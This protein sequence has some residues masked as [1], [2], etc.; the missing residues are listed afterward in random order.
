MR[1]HAV[2]Y[3]SMRPFHARL[4]TIILRTGRGTA[5]VYTATTKAGVDDGQFI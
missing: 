5:I 1:K 3:I 4:G 2:S